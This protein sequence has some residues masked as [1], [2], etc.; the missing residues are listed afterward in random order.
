[1]R[2][3]FF[4]FLNLI[5]FTSKNSIAIQFK[6]LE[7]KSGIEFWLIEDKSL[8]LVSMSFSFKGGSILDPVGKDGVMNLMTSLLDEGT[9]NFT[10][11]EYRLYKR[12]NGIKISF[13]TSKERIE[14]TFQVVKPRLQEGFYLLNESI[15]KA[16]FPIKEIKKVKSQIEASIK[17]D[18]SDISTLASNKFNESFFKDKLIGRNTKG[19]LKTLSSISRDNIQSIYKSSFIKDRLVIGISGDIESSLAKKYIDYVFGDLPSKKFENPISTLKE[20]S[21]GKKIIKIKTPQTTVVFGQKT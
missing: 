11:S 3:I 15:N 18:N 5:L 7:T 21:E 13:S 4:L 10:A 12:E 14:G 19:N 16:K 6:S 8:P 17:I 1:M 2:F 9:K 20:L